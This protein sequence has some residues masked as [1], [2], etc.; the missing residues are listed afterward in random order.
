M[1]S[2]ETHRLLTA[3]LKEIRETNRLLRLL[4]GK[5]RPK[6]RSVK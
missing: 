6:K 4:L 3:T 1:F 5:K 2:A